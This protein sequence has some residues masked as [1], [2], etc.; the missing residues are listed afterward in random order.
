[1][2]EQ[3]CTVSHQAFQQRIKDSLDGTSGKG[4]REEHDDPEDEP[5]TNRSEWGQSGFLYIIGQ[6]QIVRSRL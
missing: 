1:M 2:L 6:W 5:E 4:D 3:Y